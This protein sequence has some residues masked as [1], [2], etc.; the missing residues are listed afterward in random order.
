MEEVLLRFHHIAE[1]IFDS[2]DGRSLKNCKKACRTWKNFICDPNQKFMWIQII[3]AHEESAYLGLGPLKNRINGPKPKWS[4]LRIQSL[5][6]FVNRLKLEKDKTRTISQTFCN[7]KDK[8]DRFC[9]IMVINHTTLLKNIV[10]AVY[11]SV[12]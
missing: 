7:N 1:E 10:Q 11:I 5:K 12:S 6:D 8:L 2:L 4:K 9:K 3:K